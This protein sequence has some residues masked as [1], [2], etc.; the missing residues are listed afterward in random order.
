MP[1]TDMT[2]NNDT[3]FELVHQ[4]LAYGQVPV[5]FYRSKRT[6]LTVILAEV[7]GPVVNGY[8]TL[9]EF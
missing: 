4:V 6:G 8:F 3:S 5:H 1:P 9:G 2:V 7:D